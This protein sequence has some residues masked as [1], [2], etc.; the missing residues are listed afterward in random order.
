VETDRKGVTARVSIGCT[1]AIRVRRTTA[2]RLRKEIDTHHVQSRKVHVGAVNRAARRRGTLR[3]FRK[4]NWDPEMKIKMGLRQAVISTMVFCG[5]MLA[6]VSVD[7]RVR[8]RMESLVFGDGLSSWDNRAFE[9]GN[10]LVTAVKYQSIDNAPL[11]IFTVVGAI[12]FLFMV[13]A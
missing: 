4:R 7:P 8:E 3:Q 5:V 10:A 9:L 11:M 12:L 1:R 2:W 6:V 13:R